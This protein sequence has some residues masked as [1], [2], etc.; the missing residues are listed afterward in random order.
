MWSF[1]PLGVAPNFI[2][3]TGE[4][5]VLLAMIIAVVYAISW[6][7]LYG[8]ERIMTRFGEGKVRILNRVLG[9]VLAALAVQYVLNGLTG[10]Y[11]SLIHRSM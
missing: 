3:L 4:L 1:D 10:Y 11:G 6:F 9:I 8:S 5:G 7:V 2:A